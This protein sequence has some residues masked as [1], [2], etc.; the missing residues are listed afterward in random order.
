MDLRARITDLMGP[1]RE[2]L[3]EFVAIRSVADA[4]QF[5]AE[6]CAKAAQWVLDKFAGLGFSDVHLERTPDGSDA[7]VGLQARTRSGRAH[8]APL[9]ALRRA[10]TPR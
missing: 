4:R 2:E 1:A 5:P 9:R 10:A 8:R 6:E 3:A 7:V